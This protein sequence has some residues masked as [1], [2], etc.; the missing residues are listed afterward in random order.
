MVIV[1]IGSFVNVSSSKFYKGWFDFNSL[2]DGCSIVVSI[3]DCGSC[4][5]S[6]IL[7]SHP[8][9][10]NKLFKSEMGRWLV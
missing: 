1:F 6:S 7:A 2:D 5:A 10:N 3:W 8:F 4:D 9:S